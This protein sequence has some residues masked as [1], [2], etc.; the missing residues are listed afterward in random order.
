MSHDLGDYV[1]VKDRL[2]EFYAKYPEGSIES[3]FSFIDYAGKPAVIVTAHAY[4][5]PDD[6]HPATGLAKELIPGSTAFT[7]GAELEV[8]QTSAWGRALGALGIGVKGAI[9][10]AEE[11]AG[12]KARR[13]AE[14]KPKPAPDRR[15]QE[16]EREDPTTAVGAPYA[17]DPDPWARPAEAVVEALLGGVK[18][19]PD[20]PLRE[21]VMHGTPPTEK[22]LKW[23][24][25]L[26]QREADSMSLDE[27]EYLNALLSD[28]GFPEVEGWQYVGKQACSKII[29]K[30]KGAR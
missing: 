23:A 22:Q 21:A 24:R 18:V 14:A 25:Q 29:D 6:P 12:A 4:R 26:V 5:T 3:T 11:V 13:A 9:A 28:L 19:D 15:Q 1:E 8:C 30:L 7:R 27:V 2:T 16:A 17:G 10:S 20:H